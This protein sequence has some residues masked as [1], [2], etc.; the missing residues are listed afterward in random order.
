VTLAGQLVRFVVQFGSVI[1]LARLLTPDDFG[2]VAMVTSVVGIAEIVRDFGLSSAAI[3]AKTLS[4]AERSNLWWINTGIGALCTLFIVA[5]APLLARVYHDDRVVGIAVVL[6]GL[7]IVSGANTQL[8]ADLSRG[9][10]FS[11]LVITDVTAQISAVAVAIGMALTGW[12]YWAVVGQ[13][14]TFVVV[15]FVMN[16]LQCRWIPSRPDRHTPMAR[17]FRYGGGV[18]GTQLI[19]FA[20]NNIDNVALGAVW[21]AGPLG[22]YSRAYQLLMVPIEQINAPMTRVVLPV[23]SRAREDHETFTRYVQR[24][25]LVGTHGLGLIFAVAAGLAWPITDILFGPQWALVAPIFAAL[26]IGGV[27]RGLTQLPY[28]CFLAVGKTGD[29]LRLYL[30]TRPVMILVL[31]AGLPWGPIGVAIG[32]SVAF[33][34]YWL[35][36]LARMGSAADLDPAPLY[37]QA[38][39]SF[40][41]VSGPAGLAA[42]GAAQLVPGSVAQLLLGLGAAA[43]WLAIATLLLP[44]VRSENVALVGFVKRGLG[45]R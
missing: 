18:L 32:H 5:L 41:L 13:Q 24:A 31:L 3:Q 44:S 8:R 40:V 34:L 9:M 29:Q 25:Q 15:G 33:A 1:L 22:N 38:L 28:W 27:F 37:A 42:Y 11:S 21:G 10:R 39:R 45:R 20:T 16:A 4:H 19:G 17:F 2:V 36:A 14:I 6:S 12:G 26:A 7:V 30:W 35:V 23:L 43:A